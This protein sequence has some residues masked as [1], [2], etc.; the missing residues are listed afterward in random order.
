MTKA[1]MRFR[2][3]TLR[4]NPHKLI[5][6]SS[7]NIEELISPCTRPDSRFLG[8]GLVTVS[9]EGELYGE[10]MLEQYSQLRALQESG[11]AGLL[12]LPDMPPLYAYLK[13]LSILAE[14]VDGVITYSFVF[15]EAKDR[16]SENTDERYYTVTSTTESLWDISYSCG[17]GVDELVRL[18]PQIKYIDKVG[19][20]E[21]VRLC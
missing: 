1:A 13:K 3:H 7:S 15:V 11:A 20:G 17:V 19:K 9:G 6:G 10:D 2:G 21:R 8:R 4:H 12:T 18:N 5:I 16:I 14:P